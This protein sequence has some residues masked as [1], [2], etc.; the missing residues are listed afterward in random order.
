MKQSAILIFADCV[1]SSVYTTFAKLK[2]LHMR[3]SEYDEQ[4][5]G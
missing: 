3:K 2:W 1:L 4:C 5:K